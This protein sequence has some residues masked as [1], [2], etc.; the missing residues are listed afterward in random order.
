MHKIIQL[1]LALATLVGSLTIAPT[2]TE[3]A[4]I[5]CRP[6]CCSRNAAGVC[7]VYGGCTSVNGRCV[8]TPCP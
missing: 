4:T 8:C 7:L 5:V 6:A 2:P 1:C 3:A